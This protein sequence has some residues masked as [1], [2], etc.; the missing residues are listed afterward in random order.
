MDKNDKL[1]EKLYNHQFTEKENQE[2]KHIVNNLVQEGFS[3]IG[4][5]CPIFMKGKDDSGKAL[6]TAK[7]EEKLFIVTT[8]KEDYGYDYYV[9]DIA[10]SGDFVITDFQ[11]EWLS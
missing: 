5:G 8:A 11:E 1:T 10:D 3:S 4:Y 2:A 7:A 6:Y 9:I